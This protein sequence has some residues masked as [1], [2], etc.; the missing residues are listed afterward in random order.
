MTDVSTTT[1]SPAPTESIPGPA[2]LGVGKLRTMAAHPPRFFTG[3][4]EEYG[5]VVRFPFGNSHGYLL[6][7]PRVIQDVYIASDRKFG[8]DV[9]KIGKGNRAAPMAIILGRGL[10]TSDG[11]FH[12]TQRRRIQPIFHRQRIAGYGAT[13]ASLAAEA[14]AGWTDGQQMN[15]HEQMYE[16]SLGMVAKT[17]FDVSLDADVAHTIRTAFPRRGGPLRWEQVVPFGRF[18]IKLPLRNNRRFRKGRKALNEIIYRM[19]EERRQGPGDGDDLLSVLLSVQ[20]A[21]TGEF[22]DDELVRDEAMTLLFAGHETSSGAL[23]W[24]YHL[25]SKNPEAKKRMHAELDEVLGDRLPEVSDLPRLVWTD[26]VFSEAL[27]LYPPVW[28]TVRRTLTEYTGAGYVLPPDSFVMISPWVVHHDP[29]W[30]PEPEAFAPQRW[31]ASDGA[32]PLGGHAVAPGR[33]RMAYLP[34]GAGPRQCIG[35]AFARMEAIMAL[36]TIGRHW[37]FEA[38]NDDP[39]DVVTHITVQPRRG[40]QMIARRRR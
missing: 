9:L 30:W 20:D 11:D 3:L 12:R 33:P 21:E 28:V 17:I 5:P 31:I 13:F 14:S 29:Q 6:S 23:T 39:V 27:R 26:A 4:R 40:V 16:I 25:L 22:M 34:F 38:V 2:W 35:N 36:A 7:D 8:K 32:D 18:V 37:D 24:A 1:G 15:V 10:A 19:I